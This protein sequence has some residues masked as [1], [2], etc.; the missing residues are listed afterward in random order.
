MLGF[1]S[2][3]IPKYYQN[4]NNMKYNNQDN[5][6]QR[7]F[8][9]YKFSSYNLET[10]RLEDNKCN[11]MELGLN[12]QVFNQPPNINMTISPKSKKRPKKQKKYNILNSSY[13]RFGLLTILGISLFSYY[14]HKQ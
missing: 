14:Y 10:T 11:L 13:F 4:E 5:L 7:V 2:I 12:N 8:N 1:N 3:V 6:H 9:Q